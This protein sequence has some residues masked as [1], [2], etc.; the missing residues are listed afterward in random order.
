MNT[1]LFLYL[2]GKVTY[3]PFRLPQRMIFLFPVKLSLTPAAVFGPCTSPLVTFSILLSYYSLWFS[4]SIGSLSGFL[5]V[6]QQTNKSSQTIV[7][8]YFGLHRIYQKNC[9]HSWQ[10]SASIYSPVT[11]C[12]LISNP[13][14][15]RNSYLTGHENYQINKNFH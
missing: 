15:C 8:F 12:N 5:Y 13:I 14:L 2:H 3:S 10:R 7:L 11:S 4:L 9:L 1:L 6:I